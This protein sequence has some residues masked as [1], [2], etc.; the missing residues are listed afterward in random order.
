VCLWVGGEEEAVR[1]RHTIVGGVVRDYQR[2]EVAGSKPL[3]FA[4]LLPFMQQLVGGSPPAKAIRPNKCGV[5]KENYA[6]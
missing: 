3:S 5:L 2:S 4:L 6:C 1:G